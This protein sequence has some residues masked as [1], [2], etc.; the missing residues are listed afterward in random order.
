MAEH[1]SQLLTLFALR[2]SLRREVMVPI[3]MGI[4]P[5]SLFHAKSRV[6]RLVS[7]VN[8]LGSRPDRLLWSNLREVM[9]LRPPMASGI[10]PE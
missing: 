1:D 4:V 3:F 10:P 8:E 2:L 9:R 5:V 7:R 6:V